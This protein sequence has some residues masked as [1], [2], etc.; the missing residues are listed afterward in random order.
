MTQLNLEYNFIT[1]QHGIDGMLFKSSTQWRS[2]EVIKNFIL[3]NRLDI[4]IEAVQ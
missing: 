2:E 4:R 3:T 1:W